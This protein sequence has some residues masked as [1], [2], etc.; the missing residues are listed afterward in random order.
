MVVFL[1]KSE[2]FKGENTWISLEGCVVL[3][4]WVAAGVSEN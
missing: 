4:R 3:P 1:L 2:K